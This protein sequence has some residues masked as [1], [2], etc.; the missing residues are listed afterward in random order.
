M[1]VGFGGSQLAAMRSQVV[2]LL[3]MP[4]FGNK[5]LLSFSHTPEASLVV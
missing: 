2:R 5:F 3:L 1:D 4:Q